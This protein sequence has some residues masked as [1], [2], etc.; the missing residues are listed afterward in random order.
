MLTEDIRVSYKTKGCRALIAKRL[1]TSVPTLILVIVITSSIGHL[2]PGNPVDR[3]MGPYATEEDKEELKSKLGLDKSIL[4]H[5]AS[6]TKKLLFE[7]DMGTSIISGRP[8]SEMIFERIQPTVELAIMSIILA[9]FISIPMGVLGAIYRGRFLDDLAT[10]ATLVGVALP[11]F[12]LGPLLVLCFSVYLDILPVSERGSFSSYILPTLTLG[13]SLAGIT[14][15]MTRN[16][17]VDQMTEDYVRTARSK[18]LAESTVFFKHI[19]ANAFKPV[20][21]IL[22]LQ[23]GALL[24]GSIITEQIFDWPG[25]GSLIMQSIESRDY[26]LMQGCILFFSLVYIGV[27]LLTDCCYQ[28][29]DPKL[30]VK[31]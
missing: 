8:V 23:F 11:N 21:T 2:V 31:S 1:L 16:S 25:I 7:R 12:W 28:I 29:I 19:L 4:T 27:N 20:F 26:P 15:R 13:T 5:S 9:I 6:Y 3:I 30:R 17:I 10:V 14:C 22:S 18:G 24:T